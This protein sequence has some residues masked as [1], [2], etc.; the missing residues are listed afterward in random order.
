MV[1]TISS[2]GC[3]AASIAFRTASIREVTPVEV[4][5]WTTQTAL[6]SCA[7]SSASFASTA[8]GSTPWRQSPS[9]NSG[10]RPR[11]SASSHHRVANCPVSNISTRSP[12]DSTLTSA[13]SHAPVPEDGKMNTS[14]FVLKMP[15]IASSTSLP[16]RPNSGPRWS[17]VG[18]SM[19][20]RMRSGT[21]DGPG[22]WRKWRPL[23]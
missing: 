9:T 16:M 17:I 15:F 6:I 7:V 19:A 11:R 10:F 13:A 5:L 2:A 20:R 14:S 8:A 23:R 21:F 4:S 3:F 22:I 12:G 1:S 18:R